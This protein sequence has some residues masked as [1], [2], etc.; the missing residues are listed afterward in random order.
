[1]STQLYDPGQVPSLPGTQ[2]LY[3][4]SEEIGPDAV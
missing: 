1:M 3:L 4:C 2:F